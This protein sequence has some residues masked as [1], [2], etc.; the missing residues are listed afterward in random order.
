[1]GGPLTTQQK[2]KPFPFLAVWPNQV[3]F[4]TIKRYE[5]SYRVVS[6]MNTGGAGLRIKKVSNL[7]P[8]APFGLSNNT[9]DNKNLGPGESCSFRVKFSPV[10]I[11]DYTSGFEIETDNNDLNSYYTGLIEVKGVSVYNYWAYLLRYNRLSGTL[12]KAS[13]GQMGAGASSTQNIYVINTSD[14]EWRD[15][16]LDKSGLPAAYSVTSENCT[17]KTFGAWGYCHITV[18][19]SPD[20]DNVRSLNRKYGKYN[21]VN[22][23]TKAAGLNA[24]P[25]YP[26]VIESLNFS[27]PKGVIKLK[28]RGGIFNRQF[29]DRATVAVEGEACSKFP[30]KGVLKS[31]RYWYFR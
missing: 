20:D 30:V 26:E 10:G 1:M 14:T 7:D 24:S 17:G 31:G 18:K 19:F 21:T 22:I 9:C 12:G 13:F 3:H 2:E 23:N 15:I 28:G 4:G 29:Y 27:V 6:V 5:T 8:D 11:K 25:R 16:K